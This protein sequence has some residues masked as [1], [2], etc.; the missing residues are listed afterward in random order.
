[1]NNSFDA[2]TKSIAQSVTRRAALKK[3]GAGVAG[4]VLAAFGLANNARADKVKPC[5]SDLDCASG[6]VCCQGTC[7]DRPS[8]CDPT[9]SC[10]CYC[11]GKGKNRYGATAL[12]PCDLSYSS[13]SATCSAF[14]LC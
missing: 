10:C 7:W 4:I 3:F 12:T 9:T 11:A 6:T 13:C 5:A 8:W 1:M 14:A 2:L